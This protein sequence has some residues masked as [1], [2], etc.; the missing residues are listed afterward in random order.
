MYLL[1]DSKRYILMKNEAPIKS[2]LDGNVC[3]KV[4]DSLVAGIDVETL[5]NEY[6]YINGEL[7]KHAPITPE[8]VPGYI[9]PLTPGEVFEVLLSTI[10]PDVN[11]AND[12]VS[13]ETAA[14]MVAYYPEWEPGI[15]YTTGYRVKY[16]NI[17]YKVLQLHISQADWTPDAAHS[18]YAKILNPDPS[19]I[20]EW[21]QP[22][23]TNAYMC[24]DKV[25]HVGKTWESLIDNNVWEPGAIGT[26]S[27]WLDLTQ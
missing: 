5:A 20:P 6:A 9:A 8:I 27:L 1:L 13:E 10:M 7:V 4:D 16:D 3:V 26:E 11:E 2:T 21:E 25:K 14:R 24:G 18:L 22:T 12:A 17:L 19:D 23:S 15:E